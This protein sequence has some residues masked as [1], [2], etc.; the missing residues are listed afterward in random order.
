[1]Y[2]LDDAPLLH[3]RDPI[4]DPRRDAQIVGDE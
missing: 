3:H 2:S 4:A 1:V